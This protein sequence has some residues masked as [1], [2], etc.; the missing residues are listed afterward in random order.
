[1]ASRTIAA[2]MQQQAN[3][4]A[5]VATGTNTPTMASLPNPEDV[6]VNSAL[7][8]A[9]LEMSESLWPGNTQKAFDPKIDEYFQFCNYVYPH[10][11]YRYNLSYDKVYRFMFYV[12]F[13]NNKTKAGTKESRKA[14]REA[15]KNGIHFDPESYNNVMSTFR[16]ITTGAEITEADWPK[17]EYPISLSN[18]EQ[19]KAVFRKIYKVQI[20]KRVLSTTWDHIWQMGLDTLREHVKVRMPKAKKE[21]YAEK[22][23]GEF[24]PYA[25]VEEYP[26]IEEVLWEDSR[27]ASGRRAV[28]SGLRHRYCLL[29]LTSGIL[30]CESLYRAE[31]SDFLTIRPP[32]RAID[33]HPMLLMINQIMQ[34][35]T[36]KNRTLY[37]RTTRHINPLLCAIGA[38]AFYL[39]YRFWITQEFVDFTVDDWLD[40][41]KWFDVKLLVDVASQDFTKPM[42]NDSYAKRIKSVLTSLKLALCKLLHLGRNLGAKI[43]ELMEEEDEA[44]RRMGNW[45]PSIFDNSYSTK[46]PMSPIRKLA[47]FADG[48]SL[49][50]NTRTTVIPSDELRRMTPFG[51]WCYT[52]YDGV[53]E[54]D[55]NKYTLL[56]FL[57]FV[58][59]I[60]DVL[61]QD[62]AAMMIQ[63]PD[64][65]DHPMFEI[66]VFKTK[67]FKV[68]SYKMLIHLKT[69]Y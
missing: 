19:Y 48:N 41:R 16:G 22:L 30:R 18:F 43:L 4:V 69:K 2:R 21:S 45:N 32:K 28:A 39:C 36:N 58:C 67:E 29:Q 52:A 53:L 61:L 46:L 3:R 40:N 63:F 7:E 56:G 31:L 49:Y 50:F 65:C 9:V 12:A 1:M 23:A 37:G 8:Q 17:P 55:V 64:R 13:R 51:K 47:G 42:Q 44:I 15:V 5:V 25:A 6:G 59:E 27:T 20:A 38:I 24:A 57:K 10:D 14:R 33:V 62:A 26:R 34:G 68:S 54:R 66:E 11:L 35:K 60:N